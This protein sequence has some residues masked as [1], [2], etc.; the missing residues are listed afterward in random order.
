MADLKNLIVVVQ[1]LDTKTEAS[2]KKFES[3]EKKCGP[4]KK[5]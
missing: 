3:F 4:V 5:R 1:R 2:S